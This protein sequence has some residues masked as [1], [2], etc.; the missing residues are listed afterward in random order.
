[1]PSADGLPPPPA[2]PVRSPPAIAAGEEAIRVLGLAGGP[3]IEARIHAPAGARRAVLLC[4]PHPLYGGSM[5]SPVP[6]AIARQLAEVG[7]GRVAWA[8]FNFR[9]V[10]GSEGAYDHGHG[11]LEDARA[12]FEELRRRS[13]GAALSVCGHSFGAWVAYRLSSSEGGIER[14]LLVAPTKH[15]AYDVAMPATESPASGATPPRRTSVFIGDRDELSTVADARAIAAQIG[16]E[17]R[18]FEGFDHHF[19][20]SR[21]AL[22]EAALPVIAPEAASP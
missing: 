4:H 10:G 18:I 19:L 6:L 1:M 17:V 14:A 20:K 2:A 11:E 7:A 12:V 5:H 15:F 8:R 21:R 22:A 9:G 3:S 16:A 13:P